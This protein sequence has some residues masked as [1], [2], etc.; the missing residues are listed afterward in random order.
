M[1][2]KQRKAI[3]ELTGYKSITHG[4][5]LDCKHNTPVFG[6]GIKSYCL[7]KKEY[8]ADIEGCEHYEVGLTDLEYHG[9]ILRAVLKI[10][11]DLIC[12]TGNFQ[13]K[14]LFSMV[15]VIHTENVREFAEFFF[16]DYSTPTQAIESAILYC[17]SEV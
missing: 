2:D 9:I 17:L 11:D 8:D 16:K 6:D 14:I 1:T 12:S 15:E 13:I 5:C 10:N 4:S 7:L 3:V